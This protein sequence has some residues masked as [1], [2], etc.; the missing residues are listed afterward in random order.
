[1][2]RILLTGA[3]GGG[4]NNLVRSLRSME[5]VTFVGANMDAWAL[6]R[7]LAQPT[8]RIPP[9]KDRRRYVDAVN[10]ICR[11][12]SIDLIVPTNDTET[13]ALSEHRDHLEAPVR[14]P[15]H[16]TI[17]LCRDKLEFHRHCEDV[18]IPVATTRV[19]KSLDRL[20]EVFD[21]LDAHD[22]DTWLW[23]RMRVGNASKGALPVS[24]PAQARQWIA[25][26][27][28]MRGA[29]VDEFI[30]A[31]YLPGSDWA[32][33]GLWVDGE[34]IIGK[35]CERLEY[36]FAGKTPAGRFST[37]RVGRLVVD[38]TVSE[39]CETAVSTL[40]P[41]ASGIFSIDLKAASDGRPKI[42]EINAGRFFRIN[43][44]FNL[45]GQYNMA[46]LF[47]RWA[48]ELGEWDVPPAARTSDIGDETTYYL[49]D[50]DEEP[51]LVG[52][53]TLATQV[54]LT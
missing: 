44:A 1:M 52:E 7:S 27:R 2:K 42:T 53:S 38:P 45:S 29:A 30:V 40:D 5:D 11:E 8:Y 23:C 12:Q 22:P 34:L 32:F 18:G 16:E 10:E 20:D 51:V 26:W 13:F 4:S 43:P 46:T 39:V 49:C 14:L 54:D 19:V 31:E 15:R 17:A 9:S 50:L 3:G 37:P 41:Q 28:D 33:Q 25:Y 48:L 47:M 6:V 21:E 36:I 35:A 24:S